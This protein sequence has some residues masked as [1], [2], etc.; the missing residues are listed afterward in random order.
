MVKSCSV[1][2][3]LSIASHQ[4]KQLDVVQTFRSSAAPQS[5]SHQKE[6]VKQSAK[7]SCIPHDLEL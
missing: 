7:E 1:G 3:E 5:H 2:F 4:H 6:A